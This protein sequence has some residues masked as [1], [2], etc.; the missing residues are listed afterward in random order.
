MIG[1][2]TKISLRGTLAGDVAKR[3]SLSANHPDLYLI[4]SDLLEAHADDIICIPDGG[5]LK[6]GKKSE[7]SMF[8][9]D[10]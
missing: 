7:L 1:S 6:V 5:V 8:L 3:L 10:W 9:P 4:L 2:K